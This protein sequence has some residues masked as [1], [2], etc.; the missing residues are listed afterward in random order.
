MKNS[1][2][3]FTVF[4]KKLEMTIGLVLIWGLDCLDKLGW[5]SGKHPSPSSNSG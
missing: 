1:F 4:E 5:S 2:K 3:T